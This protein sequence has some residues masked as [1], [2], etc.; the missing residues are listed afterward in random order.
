MSSSSSSRAR[1]EGRKA[2]HPGGDPEELNPYRKSA[3]TS[4]HNDW[5]DGWEKEVAAYEREDEQKQEDRNFWESLSYGC[6]WNEGE[7]T[8]NNKPC[9]IENCAP[10]YFKNE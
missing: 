4:L 9:D 6:P 3:L 5:V 1:R 10:Y 7:C 2:F 8:V